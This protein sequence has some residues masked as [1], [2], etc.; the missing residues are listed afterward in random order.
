MDDQTAAWLA[1][2]DEAE[3]QIRRAETADPLGGALVIATDKMLRMVDPLA[4]A[5]R[6]AVAE[7]TR[8]RAFAESQDAVDIAEVLAAN[9]VLVAECE[10]LRAAGKAL[11]GS[12]YLSQEKRLEA[13]AVWREATK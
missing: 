8:L 1:L 9:S 6:A 10:R 13:W 5:L 7:V 4:A 12:V 3:V 11:A 2:V